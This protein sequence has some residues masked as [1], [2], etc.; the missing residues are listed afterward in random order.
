MNF[1]PRST[2]L[3]VLN[4]IITFVVAAI[5]FGV[6]FGQGLRAQEVILYTIISA[7]VLFWILNYIA[8]IFESRMQSEKTRP[9]ASAQSGGPTAF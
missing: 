3:V 4:L 7:A 8:S 2:A 6:G 1:V 5:G 9:S